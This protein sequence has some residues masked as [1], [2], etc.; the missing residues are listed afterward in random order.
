MRKQYFNN[1]EKWAS[2]NLT[3][4]VAKLYQWKRCCK[5][6]PSKN[7]LEL[8]HEVYPTNIDEI[9]EA[10]NDGKIK[11]LCRKCHRK[12][13][14]KKRRI[15][16]PT[17]ININTSTYINMEV[18]LNEIQEALINDAKEKGFLTLEDFKKYYTSPI[19]IKANI[20]RFK[21]LGFLKESNVLGKFDYVGD[22]NE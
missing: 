10:Y 6:C 22:T 9:L 7:Y 8:H 14:N 15:Y 21:A 4:E 17:N 11:F 2:R 20:E 5:N 13:T 18:K 3:Y 16:I 12:V 1:K 19:T